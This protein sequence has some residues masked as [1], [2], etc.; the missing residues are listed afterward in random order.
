MRLFIAAICLLFTAGHL[1]T[2]QTWSGDVNLGLALTEGNSKTLNF[3]FGFNTKAKFTKLEWDTSG[4]YL[5]H[6]SEGSETTQTS[7]ISSS[8]KGNIASRFHLFTGIKYLRDTSKDYHYQIIP[9]GGV[10]WDFVKSKKVE[11]TLKLGLSPV[12]NKILSTTATDNF[13]ALQWTQQFQWEISDHATFKQMAE[14]ISKLSD[15][16]VFILKM[17]IQLTA[18]LSKS[19]GLTL[20]ITD[21]Y[22][23]QPPASVEHKNDITLITSLT[24][25]F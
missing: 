2:A 10:G 6:R 13:I 20:K 23:S 1:F 19:W 17:E 7:E 8:L 11:G 3:T 9:N 12:F 14:M 24:H 21:R 16:T 25:K 18:S 22:D 15:L 4:S 5:N